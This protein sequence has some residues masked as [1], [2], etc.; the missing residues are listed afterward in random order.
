MQ[1]QK[2]KQEQKRQAAEAKRQAHEAADVARELK[3]V[4]T[5]ASGR[6][7]SRSGVDSGGG[8]GG[9]GAPFFFNRYAVPHQ[10]HQH[11]APDS[12]AHIELDRQLLF[13]GRATRDILSLQLQ[14]KY[15]T[16][17]AVFAAFHVALDDALLVLAQVHNSRLSETRVGQTISLAPLSRTFLTFLSLSNVP[18]PIP[19]VYTQHVSRACVAHEPTPTHTNAHARMYT[20]VHV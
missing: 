11:T 8:G 14:V 15:P 16:A 7:R 9:P 20:R 5:A 19:S 4:A 18:P 3:R 10:P 6:A 1:Q 2:Q 17:A 12:F 13:S